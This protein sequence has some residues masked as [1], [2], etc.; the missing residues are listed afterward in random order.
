MKEIK[1]TQDKVALVDDKDFKPISKH[2]WYYDTGYAAR[3]K[4]INNGRWVKVYMHREILKTPSGLHTDHIDGNKLNNQRC[5]IRVCTGNQ[6]R[7]NTKKHTDNK[8][9][10]KGVSFHKVAKRFRAAI[11]LDRKNIHLGFFDTPEEAAVVYN[12]AAERL[13]G[14]FSKLNFL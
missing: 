7:Y 8:S 5:N 1:L 12:K 10:Y 14:A 4:K 11:G 6:N 3:K 9:G 2:R 13:H